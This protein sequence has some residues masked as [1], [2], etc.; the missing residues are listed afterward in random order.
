MPPAAEQAPATTGTARRQRGA[1]LLLPVQTIRR[2][3]LLIR[4]DGTHVRAIATSSR[5]VLSMTEKQRRQFSD[6]LGTLAARIPDRESMQVVVQA[7]PIDV[8]ELVR[9]EREKTSLAQQDAIARGDRAHAIAMGRHADAQEQSLRRHSAAVAAVDLHYRIVLTA[10]PQRSS[11]DQLRVRRQPALRLTRELHEQ[12][13]RALDRTAES[14]CGDLQALDFE[15]AYILDGT[16]YCDDIARQ[17]SPSLVGADH[18]HILAPLAT[19]PDLALQQ[20]HALADHLASCPIDNTSPRRLLLGEHGARQLVHVTTTPSATWLGWL[21]NLLTAPVPWTLSL[22]LHAR[23]RLRERERQSRRR[24]RIYGANR[25]RE[26]AGKLVDW[27]EY[28]KEQESAALAAEMAMGASHGIYDVS[29]TLALGPESDPEQLSEY[30]DLATRDFSART[31]ART[32]DGR[33][34]QQAEQVAVL[35]I[36]LDRPRLTRRYAAKHMGH[37]LPLLGGSNSSPDGVPLAYSDWSRTITRLDPYDRAH[38]NHLMLIFGRSGGGKTFFT[39]LL[40][41][42][43]LEQGATGFVVDRAG[44]FNFLASTF[45][46]ARS[47]RLGGGEGAACVNPWDTPDVSKVPPSKIHFLVALHELLV[48]ER[49]ATDEF[50]LSSLETSLL[51]KAIRAVY[52]RCATTNEMPRETILHEVLLARVEEARSDGNSDVAN[53]LATLAERLSEYIEG[54]SASYL[55]DRETNVPTDAPLV[56][57]DTDGVS[58]ALAPAVLFIVTEFVTR[59]VADLRSRHLDGTDRRLGPW[60]GRVFLVLDEG[61]SVMQR[62]ATG[63]WINEQARRSRHLNL[64]MLAISQQYSDFEGEQGRALIA[65]SSIVACLRSSAE[66]VDIIA[67]GRGYSEEEVER[68]G[69]LRTVARAYSQVFVDA[70]PRGRDVW[71]VRVADVEYW[72]ATNEPERDEP[73]RRAA[74]RDADGNPWGALVR[75][76]DPDWHLQRM[77]DAAAA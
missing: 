3:G 56:I 41:K 73:L 27:E 50:D 35:P 53:T 76:N 38:L 16:S 66:E 60:A 29:I 30:V 71:T 23:D 7:T 32:H 70:G 77:L 74:L 51:A 13:A 72:I 1:G 28:A 26:R 46:G 8:D 75:L 63:Q 61:W 52:A 59:K 10:T 17:L 34:L 21:D 14:V 57:F 4:D 11:L 64:A 43:W 33:F 18:S 47:L 22:H 58:P 12:T 62:R 19:D 69:A 44:H 65:N 6:Q 20:R 24:R 5:S 48:G 37:L 15:E 40:L 68:I 36:G 9:R 55:V 45:P 67:R 49:S 54:G 2:D 39:N 31:D 42:R 25:G